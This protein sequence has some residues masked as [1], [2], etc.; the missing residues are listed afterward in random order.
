MKSTTHPNPLCSAIEADYD[1]GLLPDWLTYH[2]WWSPP[3]LYNL[4]Q[5][6]FLYCEFILVQLLKSQLFQITCLLAYQFRPLFALHGLMHMRNSPE[7]YLADTRTSRCEGFY[8]IFYAC[9]G[10]PLMLM[11]LIYYQW[12]STLGVLL[13]TFVQPF[14]DT[15]NL[16][17]PWVC[18]Q[19]ERAI[20][21]DP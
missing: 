16:T 4:W 13:S 3:P 18:P 17:T 15:S 2:L 1:V 11:P 21:S 7:P 9:C 8:T 10:A 19:H 5:I 12:L 20:I 6:P 14:N